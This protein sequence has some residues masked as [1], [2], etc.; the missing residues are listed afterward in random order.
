MLILLLLLAGD[1][2]GLHACAVVRDS[3][4][5]LSCYDKLAEGTTA[6][7]APIDGAFEALA[8]LRAA[9]R[10][11]LL[12][13]QYGAKLLETLPRVNAF[14]DTP[15]DDWRTVR[16]V[17]RSA[18]VVYQAPLGS[19]YAWQAGSSSMTRAALLVD[20]AERLRAAGPDARDSSDEKPITLP[21][22]G[23]GQL[24]EGDKVM[25]GVD[26]ML[27]DVYVAEVP[28]A[29]Q[30]TVTLDDLPVDV[31]LVLRSELGSELARDAGI[32]PKVRERLKPGKC[33]I[34]V[35]GTIPTSYSIRI[36]L[37]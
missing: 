16:T 10:I 33:R 4:Q 20:Y 31:T 6:S 21:Y 30:I 9:T 7:K 27:A 13:E 26:D 25:R 12:R 24:A 22:D 23:K 34:Y 14:L 29:G 36:A 8:D 15:G 11:G 17:L 35:M 18:V 28:A 32:R 19:V 37:K 5:R 1:P 3:L 2:D